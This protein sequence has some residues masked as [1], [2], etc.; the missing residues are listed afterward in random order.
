MLIIA[1]E[2]FGL[3]GFII[4]KKIRKGKMEYWKSD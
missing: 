4:R 2:S 3:H 1:V